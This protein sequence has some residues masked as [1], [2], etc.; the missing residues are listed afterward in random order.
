MIRTGH[1]GGKK[2]FAG[3]LRNAAFVRRRGMDGECVHAAFQFA[4]QRLV[5]QSVALQPG[6]ILKHFRHYIDAEMRLPARPVPRM[7]LVPMRFVHHFEALRRESLGQLF[8]NGILGAHG[9]R[10]R[11]AAR[12]VKS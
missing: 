4:R 10:L 3:S 8:R 12:A 2:D 1:D 6:H 5:N 9:L 11:R 7:A